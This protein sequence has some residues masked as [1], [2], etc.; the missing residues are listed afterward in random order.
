MGKFSSV[1]IIVLNHN[2]LDDA[3]E[4]LG[5]IL[6]KTKYKNFSVVVVDSGSFEN[7]AKI[8][9]QEFSDKRLK[10]VRFEENLG[11]AWANNG[12]IDNIK[13]KYVALLNND[14]VVEEEW[15]AKLVRVM[16]SDNSIA[17][18]VPK[19][20]SYCK[21]DYFDPS[22]AGGFLD[23]LGYPYTRG[24]IGVHV[25]RDEG[26]YDEEVDV[27]WGA[28]AALLLRRSALNKAGLLPEEFFAYH[29]EIDLCWRL[30]DSGYRVVSCPKSLVFHKGEAWWG[31]HR[32]Q[33][34][35]FIHRNS[36]LL[37]LKNLSFKRLL[38]V[39]P[40]RLFLDLLTAVYYL[41]LRKLDYFV[42]LA[43][44][45][46]A[47]MVMLPRVFLKKFVKR[48]SYNAQEEMRPTSVYWEYYV[49][50][51]RRFSEIVGERSEVPTVSY[52]EVLGSGD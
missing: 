46:V 44:A 34:M 8:L 49:K 14:I 42:A 11:F 30:K 50:K 5:A 39:L 29:E 3:K 6:K 38:W 15:L 35:F 7:E 2:G 48:R 23:K 18:C 26:Q 43:R 12:A 47:F 36:L 45:D 37:I 24:R 51:K 40:A 20:H 22:G 4:C 25:E 10:F 28:G 13:T 9:S 17:A 16:E 31:K 21:R 1:T 32:E 41:Y 19:F 33:K 52:D 27:F